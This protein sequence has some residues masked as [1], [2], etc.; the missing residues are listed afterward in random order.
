MKDKSIQGYLTMS[1]IIGFFIDFILLLIINT[2]NKELYNYISVGICSII[3]LIVFAIIINIHLYNYGKLNIKKSVI[4][5]IVYS[6]ISFIIGFLIEWFI[7]DKLLG[8]DIINIV[9]M[10]NAL[11]QS[12]IGIL[13]SIWFSYDYIKEIVK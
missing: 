13:I 4:F 10:V 5:L 12:S 7:I 1:T 8:K 2:Q 9:R 3:P 11:Y 6:I